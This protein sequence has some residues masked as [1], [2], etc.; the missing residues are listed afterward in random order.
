MKIASINIVLKR[1]LSI[2]MTLKT[3]TKSDETSQDYSTRS[4]LSMKHSRCSQA[5]VNID[6][7]IFASRQV[8][9]R[10]IAFRSHYMRS[11]VQ[12]LR[13]NEDVDKSQFHQRRHWSQ[14]NWHCR[15]EVCLKF[16]LYYFASD[17][18]IFCFC[19]IENDDALC[20]K[21]NTLSATFHRFCIMIARSA[22]P[23]LKINK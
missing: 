17:N 22:P 20:F 13:V 5:C 16:H 2:L 19:F 4:F 12:Q 21:A 11:L 18:E 8:C 10:P 23:C 14:F 9:S 7:V 6:F 1:L 3:F 15:H